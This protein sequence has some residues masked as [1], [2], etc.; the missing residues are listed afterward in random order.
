M[1]KI[2]AYKGYYDEFKASVGPEVIK[3]FE[4]VFEMLKTGERLPRKFMNYIY[5]SNGLYKIRVTALGH[6]YRLFFVFGKDNTVVLFNGFLKT[7]A[8]TPK[9]QKAKA[10]KIQEEYEAEM[11]A[12]SK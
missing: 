7:T 9:D 11:A 12:K 6:N 5:H 3:K 1:R 4:Y 10:F 2:V 8:K